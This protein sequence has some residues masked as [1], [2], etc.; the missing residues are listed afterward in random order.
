MWEIS[1]KSRQARRPSYWSLLF[2]VLIAGVGG[3]GKT[4]RVTG[5]VSYQGRAVVYGSV[6]FLGADKKA[7]SG[8]IG[9]DGSYAVEG[10]PPGEVKISVL[11]R[12]P[13][14]GRS[15]ARGQKPARPGEKPSAT[16][17]AV[18]GWFPLPPKYES[19]DGSGLSYTVSPGGVT[20]DI[21]L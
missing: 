14:K 7:R 10:V 17:E 2:A 21:E 11:S 15:A 12:D 20:Y 5:K 4:A 3:C 1:N 9:P 13:S 6:V 8:V 16:P 18:K 19:P